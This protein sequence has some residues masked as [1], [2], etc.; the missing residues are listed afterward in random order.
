MNNEQIIEQLELKINEHKSMI[1]N[2]AEQEDSCGGN[3]F[4]SGTEKESLLQ[5]TRLNGNL[6][7]FLGK[8]KDK[9]E[10]SNEDLLLVRRFESVYNE[11]LK[12]FTFYKAAS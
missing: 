12:E 4:L 8:L 2:A 6:E 1:L 10:I 11:L 7:L 9:E 3:N 5:L